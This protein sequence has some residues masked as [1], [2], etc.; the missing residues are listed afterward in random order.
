MKREYFKELTKKGY[1]LL[2][3]LFASLFVTA[4]AICHEFGLFHFVALNVQ[5][6]TYSFAVTSFF[7]LLSCIYI[8]ASIKNKKITVADAL[9]LSLVIG[10]V[11]L[12]VY[13]LFI[14]VSSRRIITSSA[15]L[16]VGVVL[17]G[18]RFG[19]YGKA[20]KKEK[21]P[22]NPISRY[23]KA[24]FEKYPFPVY[25]VITLIATSLCFLLFLNGCIKYYIQ[26]EFLIVMIICLLPSLLYVRKTAVANDITPFDALINSGI[27]FFPIWL[28]QIFSFEYANIKLTI[29]A[30]LFALFIVLL[31]ARFS[32]FGNTHPIKQTDCKC[33][34]KKLNQKYD[35][36]LLAGL[37][38]MITFTLSMLFKTKALPN[39]LVAN[40]Q[41]NITILSIPI[42]VLL[43]TIVITLVFSLVTALVTL[44]H[45]DVCIGDALIGVCLF[46]CIFGLISFINVINVALIAG[47]VCIALVM[48]YLLIIRSIRVK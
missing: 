25:I 31:F 44:D 28:I 32:S 8:I 6:R 16:V 21:Q 14:G 33:Y 35:L 1:L 9:T 45:H 13:T 18:I 12:V 29:W 4:I 10:G 15:M 24:L 43:L 20:I 30:I 37:G 48:T 27:I 38:G 34:F 7:I 11:A 26:T 36:L 41:P 2:A 17:F 22:K 19:L 46:A 47:I 5:R 40:G 42:A 23:Y 3:F 39:G